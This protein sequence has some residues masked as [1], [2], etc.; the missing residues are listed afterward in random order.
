MTPPTP[1]TSVPKF[2][3]TG[4][5]RLDSLLNGGVPAGSA[6]LV[7]GPPFL[8]K[9]V[10]ARRMVL[11]G[12]GLGVPSV[13]VITN[14]ATA[15]LRRQFVASDKAYPA[16]EKL[17]MVRFVDTYAKGIGAADAF[18]DAIYL[19]GALDLNG[20]AGAVNRM[21]AELL[22]SHA[23]HTL[24]LDSVSTLVAYSNAQTAFRFLQN[25]IGRTRRAGATSLFLMD[26][27]MHT[28]ADVQTFK[29]LMTG[30]I[31]VRESSGGHQIQ[32]QGLGATSNPG[33][34][35]YKFDER[36]FEVTGS[37]AAGRIR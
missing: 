21:E 23:A 5:K 6:V 4:V 17:H 7:Y 34:V 27:G 1:A 15:D 30:T 8:G 20:L 25:L 12:L 18:P 37:F 32:V 3:P 10:L 14:T 35:D 33:W 31:E 24:V 28:P 22:A 16:H 26:H 2:V 9:E 29:H 13:N 19:D 36:S 11:A